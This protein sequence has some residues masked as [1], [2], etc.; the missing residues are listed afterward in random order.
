MRSVRKDLVVLRT[1][2]Q[3]GPRFAAGTLTLPARSSRSGV[4]ASVARLPSTLNSTRV[5]L[6]NPQGVPHLLGNGHLSLTRNSRRDLHHTS[7]L[8]CRSKATPVLPVS[9]WRNRVTDAAHRP[10]SSCADW[11][12]A[13][14]GCQ[15]PGSELILRSSRADERGTSEKASATNDKVLLTSRAR[16]S[17]SLRK[18]SAGE[19][20]R[21]SR[22]GP[23]ATGRAWAAATRA[24]RRS[25]CSV[26]HSAW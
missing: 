26:G 4:R 5:S 2:S 21:R 24:P 23:C 11:A 25:R 1:S 7:L 16:L 10:R 18:K 22:S 19:M 13:R 14:R 15:A 9:T 3:L 12:A 17:S 6:A 20:P 8:G